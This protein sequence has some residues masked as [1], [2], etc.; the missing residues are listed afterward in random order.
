MPRAEAT[1][2]LRLYIAGQTP[3]S[4]AAL[5]NLKRACSEHLAGHYRLEVIDLLLHPELAGR[6]QILCIP[7]L[8]RKSPHPVVK[9]LGDLSNT[10]NLLLGLDV[11]PAATPAVTH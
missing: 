10:E 1:W 9:L 8:V 2:D 7:T 5:A 3:K 11:A 6:D 4:L